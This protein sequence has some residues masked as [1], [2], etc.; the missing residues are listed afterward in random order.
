MSNY[1][2]VIINGVLE[3][4]NFGM[5][6]RWNGGSLVEE[7]SRSLHHSDLNLAVNLSFLRH[8]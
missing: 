3:C 4:W 5:V 2:V 8:S 6:E 1:E 7:F